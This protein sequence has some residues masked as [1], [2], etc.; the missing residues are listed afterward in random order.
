MIKRN[1]QGKGFQCQVTC[2]P[3]PIV[4]TPAPNPALAKPWTGCKCGTPNRWV[5]EKK[6]F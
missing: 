4:A 5:T 3:A 6:H 1:F 2:S